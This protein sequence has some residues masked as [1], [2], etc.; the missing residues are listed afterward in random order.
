MV[1][2]AATAPHAPGRVLAQ[3]PKAGDRGLLQATIV[4]NAPPPPPPPPRHT[5]IHTYTLW[6]T[7]RLQTRTS[8][9]LGHRHPQKCPVTL[10]RGPICSRSQ[11][12]MY[13]RFL[14]DV[15]K[16]L[17]RIE[18]KILQGFSCKVSHEQSLESLQDLTRSYMTFP[19]GYIHTIIYR[20]ECET[21][22]MMSAE[23]NVTS[24]RLHM[25]IYE[26]KRSS[27]SPASPLAAYP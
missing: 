8:C 25:I 2:A 10:A 15:C 9:H 3:A 6:Q 4:R 14:Q 19:I 20:R 21:L 5:T 16:F 27:E 13:E 23:S 7:S 18:C 1:T 22:D 12:R 26:E 11:Y 17:A 24:G